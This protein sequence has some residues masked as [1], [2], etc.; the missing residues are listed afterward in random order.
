MIHKKS[1]CFDKDTEKKG[2]FM[3][4]GKEDETKNK[5]AAGSGGMPKLNDEV[6]EDEAADD[7]FCIAKSAENEDAKK[8]LLEQTVTSSYVL[9]MTG[10]ISF[11]PPLSSY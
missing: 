11:H 4:D 10:N 6:E 5:A 2:K 8:S 3:D 9:S 1:A 7:D